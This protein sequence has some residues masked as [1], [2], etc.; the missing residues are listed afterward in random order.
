[1]KNFFTSMFG[2][3]LA[4]CVFFTGLALLLVGLFS[5]LN[6]AAE[7]GAP[8]IEKGSYLT[9][10]LSANITD[11]PPQ[12]D[13]GKLFARMRGEDLPEVIQLRMLT[14][15]LKT[16]AADDDIAGVYLTGSF[17]PEGFGTGYAALK[18][19][20]AALQEMRNAG[21]PVIAHLLSAEAR[22]LYIASAASEVVLDPY[23]VVALQG[24]ASVPMFYKGALEKF[25]IGVQVTRA[26]KYK[27]A[28]EPF[29]RTDMS[30]ESREQSQLLMDAIW[31]SLLVDIAAG[32]ELS[33]QELQSIADKTPILL[34]QDALA[35]KLVT[36][37]AYRDEVLEDLKQRTGR[38]GSK[39]AFKQVTM[40]DYL[41]TFPDKTAPA[42]PEGDDEKE[43]T[44]KNDSTAKIAV[45]YA[46]GV[47]VDGTGEPHEIGGARFSR[48]LRKLRQD[49][50][51]KAIV[52]R[53]NSPGGS[54]TASEHIQRELRLARETK[55]VIISMG[56][57]AA[58]GGYWISAYGNRIFAEPNTI[59]GSIG[60]FG[61]FFNFQGLANNLGLTFDQVKTARFADMDS[62]TR[63][64][65]PEEMALIQNLIDQIYGDF[66]SKVA[67][68]R[69]LD[70]AKVEE[71]AQ[72]R[73]WSGREALKLG[74]IDEVGGLDQAIH[75]AAKEAKLGDNYELLEYPRKKGFSELFQEALEQLGGAKLS[76]SGGSLSKIMTQIQREIRAVNQFNDPRGVYAR[77]PL[78]FQLR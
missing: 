21:K 72:G 77:L 16:A 52:L 15:A 3:L 35:A 36:R 58:S 13:G 12:V 48:E 43:E 41:N 4:L 76:A 51:V 64:K 47:I 17:R 78:E 25:G 33:V 31:E 67:E 61:A 74:L 42:T 54:A 53:V 59:T 73:V 30:P 8:N 38:K 37:V 18:E 1:M 23:G 32:R 10:D 57:Y 56:S 70:R 14:W 46:E 75:F 71:I 65:T 63:Q 20:H 68:G 11:A 5:A 69:K 27:S 44:N 24:L 9:L 26:G 45:V 49:K 29:T 40:H 28:V 7:K 2:A 66:L 6:M 19:M 60:V 34:P 62:P 50:S 22:E 55:P 39:K